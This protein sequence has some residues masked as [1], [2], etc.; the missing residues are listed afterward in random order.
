M[1]PPRSTC[2]FKTLL[3]NGYAHVLSSHP[4]LNSHGASG[5]VD[6]AH[7]K[8]SSELKLILKGP[9]NAAN[10]TDYRESPVDTTEIKC[11]TR[12]FRGDEEVLSVI[13]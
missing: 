7:R 8:W 5:V 2:S 6:L 4:V 9:S 1:P 12:T 10:R 13:A 3:I 11:V